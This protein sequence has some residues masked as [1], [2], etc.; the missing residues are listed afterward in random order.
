MAFTTGT[1]T[2]Y[3][4][5]LDDLRLWLTGTLGWTQLQW[6]SPASITDT[7]TLSVRGPGSGSGR[8][9]Y[10]N[11]VSQSNVIDGAYGWQLWGATGF[12]VSS[13]IDAQPGVMGPAY[14]NTWENTIDYW[15]YGNARH[16]KVVAKVSTNYVSCYCGFSLPFAL[17]AEYPFPLAIIGNYYTLEAAD[18]AQSRNRFIADP[19]DGAAIYRTR[20]NVVRDIQNHTTGTS[21]I[22]P[23]G[24][25]RAFMW[26]MATG[27]V[28]ANSTAT[29]DV[30]DWARGGFTNMRLNANNETPLFAC[31]IVDMTQGNMSAALDGVYVLSGFSKSPEQTVSLG[32][33]TFRLF[34]NIFRNT[35]RDFMAIE[36]V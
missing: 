32:G 34:Q 2:D 7:A 17:P 3:H 11:I 16:F 35:A 4:D 6:D 22:K 14:F 19:G 36:E 33:R 20:T 8:E 9:A 21:D 15:F 27:K 24:G 26:P 5:M 23:F 31:H 30:Q 12:D 25:Q 1:A 13:D 10:V 18:V 29:N 28:Q